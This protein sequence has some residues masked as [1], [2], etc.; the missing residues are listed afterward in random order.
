MAAGRRTLDL[1]TQR[2][3]ITDF[4]TSHPF[5]TIVPMVSLQLLD[6]IRQQLAAGIPKEEIS[7]SLIASSWQVSDINEAFASISPSPSTQVPVQNSVQPTVSSHKGMMPVV[8]VLFLL[9]GVGGAFAAYH[10]GIFTS[11]VA[12]TV[13][14]TSSQDNFNTKPTKLIDLSPYDLEKSKN[15]GQK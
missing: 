10:Y 4:P 7:K 11:P 2:K 1:S 6:Y 5:G 12:T 3:F 15:S 14:Q 13:P 9:V 8:I